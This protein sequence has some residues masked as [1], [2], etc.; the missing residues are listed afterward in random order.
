MLRFA[1]ANY[2]ISDT[3]SALSWVSQERNRVINRVTLNGSAGGYLQALIVWA[4]ECLKSNS[5]AQAG[6]YIEAFNVLRRGCLLPQGILL[7]LVWFL[8]LR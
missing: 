8:P 4:V 3:L 7:G 5:S 6:A 1:D 2:A